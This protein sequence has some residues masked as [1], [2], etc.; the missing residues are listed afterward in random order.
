MELVNI[1]KLLQKYLEAETSI[2]EEKELKNYFL[3]Y[4]VAPELEKY[5]GLFTYFSNNK[6]ERFT[7]TINLKPKP[8]KWKWLS[9]AASVALLV[10]VY[11]GYQY[12]QQKKAEKI[13]A[14]TMHALGYLSH[15]L[16]KSATAV[17]HL[18]QFN[19]TTNK[20]LK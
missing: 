17:A 6:Q 19:N 3:N 15:S 16:N 11:S 12:N 7:K 2:A 8:N 14:Q 9:I 18:N 5:K 4:K 10:G 13:Y 20:V 1:K